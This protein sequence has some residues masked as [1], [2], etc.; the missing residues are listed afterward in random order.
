MIRLIF[1]F[2]I[3]FATIAQAQD[4]EFAAIDNNMLYIPKAMTN[5]TT[6]IASFI[7]INYKT[8]KERCR[9]IYRWVTYNIKYDTDS[10]YVFNWGADPERKVTDALRRR[11]GVC[12]N[13]AA[14]FNEIARNCGI[15]SFVISGYTKQSGF[16]EKNGHSWC[17][18]KIDDEWLLCD[19]TWDE[20]YS[21]HANYFLVPPSLFI[22]SH[23]P[24][25]PIWQLLDPPISQQAFYSG[26]YLLG[27]GQT[28]YDYA[29]SIKTFLQ[30]TELQQLEATAARMRKAGIGNEQ[31]RIR[32]A[33]LNMQASIIYESRD[34]A[35]YNAAVEYVNKAR[36]IFNDFV[37]YRNNYFIPVSTDAELAGILSP[38]DSLLVAAEK[39]LDEVDRS[40]VN[41]QYDT[42]P[43]RIEINNFRARVEKQKGFLKRY[44]A[45][46]EEERKKMFYE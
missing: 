21:S 5:S 28:K 34:M 9:A 3:C 12:E 11:K 20:G 35:E 41:A 16:I 14:I 19:P 17:A 36:N 13:F 40:T 33:Y 8:E 10:M 15:Q 38:I 4:V 29:D 32:L 44:L 23:M 37:Q 45:K 2:F 24:F 43:L 1:A 22:Q 46:E 25:D 7:N 30:M 39:K 26:N 6:G 27:K 31:T 42:G 18:V